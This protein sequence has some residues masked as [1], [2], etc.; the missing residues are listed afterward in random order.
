M[1]YGQSYYTLRSIFFDRVP[2]PFI[3]VHLRV[4]DVGKDIPVGHTSTINPMVDGLQSPQTVEVDFPEVEKAKF[5]LWL[6]ELW[7]E[8]DESITRFYETGSFVSGKYESENNLQIPLQVRTK[9]EVLDAFCFFIPATVGF[10]WTMVKR[11]A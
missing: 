7:R 10:L 11:V 6:R 9:R 5:D 2:P 1:E 4:F 3:H 8:K